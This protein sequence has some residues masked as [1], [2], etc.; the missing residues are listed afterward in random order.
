MARAE[1]FFEELGYSPTQKI[2]E[3]LELKL[4]RV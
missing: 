4:R 1:G 3:Q 2:L